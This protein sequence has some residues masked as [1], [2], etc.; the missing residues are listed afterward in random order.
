[1]GKQ[2]MT[3]PTDKR[4]SGRTGVLLFHGLLGSAVELRYIANTLS[5]EGYDVVCPELTGYSVTRPANG[6]TN[7]K[8]WLAEAEAQ[9]LKL[10]ASC[11]RVFVG[12]HS[13]GALLALL[14]AAKYDNEVAGVTLYA[15]VLWLNGWSV[16]GYA[17]LFRLVTQKWFANLFE[18]PALQGSGIKDARIR[19]FVLKSAGQAKSAANPGFRAGGGYVLERRWLANAVRRKLNLVTKPVLI[20]HPRDDDYADL[21]NASYLQRKIKSVVEMVVLDDCYHFI[22]IDRQRD[23]VAART[24][25]FARRIEKRAR[26]AAKPAKV[27]TLRPADGAI[28]GLAAAAV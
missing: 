19:D 25:E 8:A 26:P 14:I 16:P 3:A 18:F 9:F 5:R 12:G 7:W 11:D 2:I 21:N 17:K 22:T 24:V 28:A 20:L 15:P 10:R 27:A 13:T 23:I 4:E 6:D 1:M